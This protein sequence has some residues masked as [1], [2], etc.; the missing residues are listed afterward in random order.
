MSN[1]Y[2]KYIILYAGF[3][4]TCFK[5]FLSLFSSPRVLLTLSSN[6]FQLASKS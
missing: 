6:D 5:S 1:Y 4:V 2:K 3:N